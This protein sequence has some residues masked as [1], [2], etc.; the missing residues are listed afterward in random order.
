MIV[1]KKSQF[2]ELVHVANLSLNQL[3][4]QLP[5]QKW[6]SIAN[7]HSFRG[8][9]WCLQALNACY[10]LL[11]VQRFVAWRIL[12]SWHVKQSCLSKYICIINMCL[13][14]NWLVMFLCSWKKW[15][16]DFWNQTGISWI[17]P[18]FH[19]L[20][21]FFLFLCFRLFGLTFH[22]FLPGKPTIRHPFF[23]S[24]N[25]LM[26]PSQHNS[27]YFPVYCLVAIIQVSAARIVF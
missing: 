18:I 27:C 7:C 8:S 16:L 14:H 21:V 19:V 20:K 24:T 6:L 10:L 5:F 9:S 23:P 2:L 12:N 25:D 4:N 26:W 22:Q 17:L 3:V 13:Y 11:L 1:K 15:T